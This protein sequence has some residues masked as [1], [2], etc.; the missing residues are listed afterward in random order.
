[1][2]RRMGTNEDMGD[3]L[4]ANLGLVIKGDIYE[5]RDLLKAVQE[6]IEKSPTAQLVY[7]KL[8]ADKLWIKEGSREE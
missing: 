3:D 4:K 7:K 6:T 8:S 1:M 2:V 5:L